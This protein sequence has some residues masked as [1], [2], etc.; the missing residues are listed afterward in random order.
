MDMRMN[1]QNAVAWFVQ[2]DKVVL[3]SFIDVVAALRTRGGQRLHQAEVA[4]TAR[5]HVPILSRRGWK[6]ILKKPYRMLFKEELFVL[7]TGMHTG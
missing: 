3:L 6:L 1:Q 4:G 7:R 2:D 5:R